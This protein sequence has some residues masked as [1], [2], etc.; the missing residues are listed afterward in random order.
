MSEM[1]SLLIN[2]W[3]TTVG[4]VQQTMNEYP[5]LAYGLSVSKKMIRVGK[6]LLEQMSVES[7]L[8]QWLR[9]FV[10]RSDALASTI[11]RLIDVLY[12]GND[13]MSYDFHE[14]FASGHVLYRQVLPFQWYNFKDT[15]DIVKVAD[16]AGWTTSMEG[17]NTD[18]S[19][20][21]K[22]LQHDLL[23]VIG[24]VSQALKSKTVIPPFS[25]TALGEQFFMCF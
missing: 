8:R 21:M 1:K 15:P 17:Q 2:Y 24:A 23:E 10:G 5:V 19:I 9:Q 22:A 14:D 25:A 13:L 12:H 18:S 7:N 3:N 11:V 20:D 6:A 16:L 4:L